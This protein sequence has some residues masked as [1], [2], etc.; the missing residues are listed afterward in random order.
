M[1]CTGGC[2]NPDSFHPEETESLSGV[3]LI[4]LDLGQTILAML[5]SLFEVR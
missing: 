5:K 1:C 2:I 3:Y 4:P